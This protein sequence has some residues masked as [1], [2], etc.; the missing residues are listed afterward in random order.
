M[1]ICSKCNLEKDDS[2]FPKRRNRC[3]SC[4]RQYLKIYRQNN[5]QKIRES[6]KRYCQNNSDKM[7]ERYKRYCQNNPEKTKER[8]KRY[9]QNNNN[10]KKAMW[11][12]AYQRSKEKQLSFDL[13]EEDIHIPEICPVL[14]FALKRSERGTPNDDSPS[15]DRIFP[16]KGYVKG[17]VIVVSHKVNTIKNN[18]TPEE[19]IAVGEFYKKLIEQSKNDGN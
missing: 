16:E 3:K 10:P 9:R 13:Q 6:N 14:G 8:H 5:L 19:I 15:L 1:K 17:N 7:K 18:A 2:E 11:K 12:R 4:F